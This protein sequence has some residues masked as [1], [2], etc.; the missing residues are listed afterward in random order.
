MRKNPFHSKQIRDKIQA[1]NL[2]RRLE[3]NALGQLKNNKGELIE[4]TSSQLRAAEMLLDRSIPKL[5]TIQY[6]GDE[7]NPIVNKWEIEVVHTDKITQEIR[8]INAETDNPGE[9][10]KIPHDKKAV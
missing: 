8:K 4:M 5:Q 3:L 2:I 1:V 7:D 6:I 9:A 10:A